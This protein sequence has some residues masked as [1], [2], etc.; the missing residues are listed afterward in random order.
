LSYLLL[1][2]A[3]PLARMTR[4]MT[5][6]A[7]VAV[8]ADNREVLL[9]RH[10]YAPGWILPGGGVEQGESTLAAAIREIRE[11]AGII[12]EE[13]LQL[14]GVHSNHQSFRGDHLITYVLRRF[15]Q[16]D[17]APTSEIAAARF[18]PLNDLPSDTTTGSQARIREIMTG[19]APD[20]LW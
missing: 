6:G 4:G 1:K 15:H 17:W 14:H 11:E 7:R 13:P 20:P 2:T 9:I 10:S 16:E 8:I 12:A 18:F 5:L 3:R 19:A